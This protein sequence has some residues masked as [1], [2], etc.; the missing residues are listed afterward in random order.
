[1]RRTNR[2]DEYLCAL[3]RESRAFIWDRCHDHGYDRAPLCASC[4]TFEGKGVAFPRRKE[5]S[6]AHLLRC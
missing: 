3:C 6:V 2:A 5:G 4:N 1:M